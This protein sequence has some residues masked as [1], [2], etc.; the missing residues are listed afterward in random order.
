LEGAIIFQLHWKQ[1]LKIKEGCYIHTEAF[2]GGELKH[3][4]IALIEKGTP[5]IIHLSKGEEEEN[6]L[7][8]AM[9]LKSRGAY[10]IGIGNKN[11][12]I[13]IFY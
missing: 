9:E 12:K 2:A 1:T 8:N 11:K 4:V 5:C 6:T 7:I 10:I 3:G 13:L